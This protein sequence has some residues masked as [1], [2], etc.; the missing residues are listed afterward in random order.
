MHAPAVL[1]ASVGLACAWAAP[2]RAQAPSAK[3]NILFLLSDDHS[4][5]FLGCYGDTNVKTPNLDRLALSGI[6]FH[7]FFTGA[8]QCVPSRATLLTGR[9]AVA[10]RMT[11]FSSPLP[12]D[13]VTWLDLLRRDAGY[14]TGT[15]GR[16][17]H[18]DGDK[19]SDLLQSLGLQTFGG[20]LD[21]VQPGKDADTPGL[22]GAFL[23]RKPSDK[24]FA[25]WLNFSD[26]HHPW[27]AEDDPPDPASLK[28]PPHWPDLPGMRQDLAKYCGEVGRLDRTVGQVLA[29]LEQRGFATN[30]LIVFAGDNGLA[31]PHGKGS[32][33]DPGLNVPFFVT[34]PGVV[35]PGGESRFL[36]S[37]EDLG[38][39]LLAA[40][41]LP[42]APK[43]SG[44]SLLP[45]LRGEPFTPRRFLFA[46]RGPHGSATVSAN[47]S[48]SG[49]DL[50]RC[51]RSDRFK[52]IYNATPWIP[53]S[54]VDSAGGAAW[55]Q[56]RAAHDQGQLAAPLAAAYFTAPRP[57]YE[58]YDLEKDPSE[59]TNV[60]GQPAYREQERELRAAL[61]E[62]MIRDFDYLPLPAELPAPGAQKLDRAQRFKALDTDRDGRLDRAEFSLNRQAADAESWFARRDADRDGFLSRDE[63]INEPAPKAPDGVSAK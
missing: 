37:A 58:L 5:P 38:P 50:S 14:F 22:L 60:S 59:L 27:T 15:A 28:L 29:L 52:F 48:S 63:Y 35:K 55:Q 23:D 7:R 12:P 19:K 41:G 31:L 40:A 51:V 56:I 54:P 44:K 46:E 17:H 13:E 57:V 45:L 18:L 9:S 2:L 6:R 16:S 24:P 34:W 33:Y 62:Q 10:A 43:M 47:M 53:Y 39:T 8:P 32:L 11:R 61:T 42:P 1:L 20:R 25:F 21:F 4:Y 36:V 3:P 49:Y 30:T 26:P